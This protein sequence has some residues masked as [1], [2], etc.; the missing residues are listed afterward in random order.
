MFELKPC[1]FCGGK[2]E[3]HERACYFGCAFKMYYAIECCDCLCEIG[4][5]ETE[6]DVVIAW[7]RR[8]SDDD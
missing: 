3:I 4:D 5:L 8:E 7:N 1:P 6:T 2:A